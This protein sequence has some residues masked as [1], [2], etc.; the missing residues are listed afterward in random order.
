MSTATVRR[1][2]FVPL[3]V[4]F[5][6]WVLWWWE[7]RQVVPKEGLAWTQH[8]W[9]CIYP[10][11]FLTVTIFLWPLYCTFAMSWRWALV[12]GVLL[13]GASWM[14]Y[15][16]AHSIFQTLYLEGLLTD[17]RNL[18]AWSL[19]KLLG[20]ALSLAICYFLPLWH[21]HKTTDGMH[22]LTLVEVFIL[23]VPCSLIT[24]ELFPIGN[25]EI[26]FMNAVKLGYPVFWTVI[27]LGYLSRAVAE[28]WI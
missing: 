4:A 7:W 18:A 11:I 21:Y 12:Y 25:A 16:S 24:L 17:N 10:I 14:T 1:S 3:V 13:S 9:N 5:L 28:E 19:W 2:W 15:Y 8:D 6:C 27:G 23:V 20:I 26:S 22:I